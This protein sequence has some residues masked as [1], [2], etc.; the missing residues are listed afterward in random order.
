MTTQKK[1]L[2]LLFMTKP[3]KILRISYMTMQKI[4]NTQK[5]C[6]CRLCGDR[7]ETGINE[8][9]DKAWLGGKGDPLGIVQEI[10]IWSCWYMVN[11]QSRISPGK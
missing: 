2:R 11:A 7:D 6:K 4:D 10:K 9:Q 5:N 1:Y 8:I 3:K